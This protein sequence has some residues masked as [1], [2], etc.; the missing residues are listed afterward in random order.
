MEPTTTPGANLRIVQKARQAG[1]SRSAFI[2]RLKV[3]PKETLHLMLDRALHGTQYTLDIQAELVR[4]A[5]PA[6]IVDDDTL[7][8]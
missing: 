1:D 7:P 8:F 3:Y 2:H 4:R 6:C 5:T